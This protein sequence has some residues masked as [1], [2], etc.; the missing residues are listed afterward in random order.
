MSGPA[1]IR[2]VAP[3]HGQGLS[4]IA[5][6]L[7]AQ[8]A[9]N[10]RAVTLLSQG[11]DDL[12]AMA[13]V[14][15]VG[16]GEEL[17]LGPRLVAA[18]HPRLFGDLVVEEVPVGGVGDGQPDITLLTLRGPDYLSLRSASAAGIPVDGVVLI[19]EPW[20][21]L[22]AADVSSVLGAPVVAEIAHSDAVARAIDAGLILTRTPALATFR[23]LARIAAHGLHPAFAAVA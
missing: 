12:C 2:L 20:R 18:S 22:D 8:A 10:D 7:A 5:L 23:A 4:T 3:R 21:A 6:A 14:P 1:H 16:P 11:L 19:R 9:A 15:M 13:G 17:H